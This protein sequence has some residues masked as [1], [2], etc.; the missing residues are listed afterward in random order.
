MMFKNK[1]QIVKEAE[2]LENMLSDLVYELEERL[3]KA[4]R[5]LW[6]AKRRKQRRQIK[7]K[8]LPDFEQR[9]LINGD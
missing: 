7:V 6:M 8:S 3:E 5:A 9:V 1:T 2:N 4:K